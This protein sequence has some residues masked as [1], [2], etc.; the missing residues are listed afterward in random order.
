MPGRIGKLVLA[1]ICTLFAVGISFHSAEGKNHKGGGG[2]PSCDA[3]TGR[4]EV[5]I[6]GSC[7]SIQAAIDAA[8]GTA[9][10]PVVIDVLPGTY[11]ENLVL[12]SYVHLKGGG[13]DVTS[14]QAADSALPVASISLLT[15]VAV[16]GFRIT[17][18]L[19]GIDVNGSSP[20]IT[21]NELTG[22]SASGVFS[23]DNASP[24]ISGNLI[25]GNGQHGIASLRSSSP[26]ITDNEVTNNTLSGI[27]I[28]DN[29]S[30]TVSGNLVS[31]SG[32]NGIDI[33]LVS[34]PT[35]I[36]NTIVGN[37]GWGV[38]DRESSTSLIS[39]NRITGNASGG[40]E[41]TLTSS[42]TIVH[43]K[44]TDNT[45]ASMP[46]DLLIASGSNP[47]VSYNIFDTFNGTF[48]IGQY[49]LT[50]GGAPAPAP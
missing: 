30:P 24:I 49:N 15:N 27:V 41:V 20:T 28:R 31:G 43:N 7:N 14:I 6:S 36:G 50:S 44:I 39:G 3:S 45:G 18:G 38:S 2:G 35:V 10:N 32:V 42:P 37:T 11:T 33:S 46:L 29:S 13:R 5:S 40:V 17:G 9:A 21:G 8:S 22:N 48:G 26:L 23:H 25:N 47:H 4:I 1:G 34:S 16:S 19:Y 12:K